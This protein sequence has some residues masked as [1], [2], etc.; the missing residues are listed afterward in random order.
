MTGKGVVW[1]S[2]GIRVAGDEL[3]VGWVGGGGRQR[4]FPQKPPLDLPSLYGTQ[5]R[6]SCAQGVDSYLPLAALSEH[7]IVLATWQL[8]PDSPGARA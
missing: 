1:R 5:R 8:Q 2:P 4:I 6:P 7:R 3:G